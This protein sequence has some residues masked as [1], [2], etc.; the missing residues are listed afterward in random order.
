MRR[1]V[2]WFSRARKHSTRPAAWMLAGVASS[3]L[4]L[5]SC[6]APTSTDNT[7]DS[8]NSDSAAITTPVPIATA[9]GAP[10]TTLSSTANAELNTESASLNDARVFYRWFSMAGH[11]ELSEAQ[12]RV[13]EEWISGYQEARGEGDDSGVATPELNVQP[14]LT[15]S[16]EEAIGIRLEA[17]EFL[18]ASGAAS[19]HTLWYLPQEHQALETKDLF[20]DDATW[21]KLLELA[22][23]ALSKHP[24]VFPDAPADVDETYLDSLN[25]D[26][27]GNGLLEFDEYTVAAGAVGAPVITIAAADLE[28]LLNKAG[29]KVRTAGM[30]AE[31]STQAASSSSVVSSEAPGTVTAP[32]D[33]AAPPSQSN[34]D[35]AVT[36][37]IALTFDDGPGPYTQQLLDTLGEYNAKATFFVVGSNVDRYTETLMRE[38][39]EGHEIGNHTWSHRSLPT[40]SEDGVSDELESTSDAISNVLGYAPQLVRP[41]YGAT[42]PT[43][44]QL[45]HSPVVLWDVDTLDWKSRNAAAVVDEA[46]TGAHAGAIVL[47]H[48]I[49]SSTVNAVPEILKQLSGQ[50]YEFVTV[51]Q[52]LASKNPAAGVVYSTGPAPK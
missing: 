15:A 28:P 19:Y 50:G 35:C 45:T 27:A 1:P 44:N 36:K 47:M 49:H 51:S 34:V 38:A 7:A 32:P 4:I 33:A 40:L 2:Q 22:K 46:V 48:D 31:T 25:F 41:P 8:S 52:L 20:T 10:E 9:P 39:A 12:L 23:T 17:F 16:T 24:D 14:V 29:K 30:S 13:I 21:A 11:A 42:S 3:A 43:V 6:T 26:S 18:G 5:T 37:C